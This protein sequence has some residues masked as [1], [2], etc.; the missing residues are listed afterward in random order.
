MTPRQAAA[1]V[2]GTFTEGPLRRIRLHAP[3]LADRL[4]PG[5][6]VTAATGD[7]LRQPLLPAAIHATG[8]DLLL[9]PDHPAATLVPDDAIDLLGPLGRPLAPG[10]PPVRLLLMADTP[11][12]PTLFPMLD[13]ALAEESQV[14]LLL[15]DGD[16]ET[17]YPPALLPPAL[18]FHR[19]DGNV[20]RATEPVRTLLMWAD[21]MLVATD[22]RRYPALR[23]L[24]TDVRLAPAADLAQA[25]LL[26]TIVCGVGACRGCAVDMRRGYRQACTDGPFFN[27]LELEVL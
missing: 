10:D 23:R 17:A 19:L 13:Q 22:P 5:Q 20:L 1:T 3:A 8:L 2:T 7:V 25:L 11:H 27:L 12:L 15:L 4:H 24:V 9:P 6:F 18:E 16:G 14:A 21:R 26:P